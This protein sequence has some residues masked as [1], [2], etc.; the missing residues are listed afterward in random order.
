MKFDNIITMNTSIIVGGRRHYFNYGED[1]DGNLIVEVDLHRMTRHEAK[2]VIN[3]IISMYDF[4]FTIVLIHG[5]N[6]GTILKNMIQ[7]EIN[8]KRISM[9][10]RDVYNKGETTLLI[11]SKE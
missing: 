1:D 4:N 3:N 6:N 8:S 7:Y 2:Y 11:N 9:K 5:Y 10:Y